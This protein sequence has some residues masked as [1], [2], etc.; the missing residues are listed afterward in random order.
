MLLSSSVVFFVGL[1]IGSALSLFHRECNLKVPKNYSISLPPKILDVEGNQVPLPIEI[2]SGVTE[3]EFVDEQTGRI[4]ICLAFE[5]KWH[6]PNIFA[7]EENRNCFGKFPL[8]GFRAKFWTPPLMYENVRKTANP[9][10][11]QNLQYGVVTRDHKIV[12]TQF[13]DNEIACKFDFRR[14]PFDQHNCPY[15]I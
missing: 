4:G 6:D 15:R 1:Q 10:K 7:L 8:E 3:I 9:M 2:H 12:I 11:N 13:M 14:Y 5:I